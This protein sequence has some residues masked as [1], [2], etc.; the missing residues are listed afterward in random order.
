[1][2][3][4]NCKITG[5]SVSSDAYHQQK[6]ER[7][8]PR[9]PVSP[10]MLKSFA[11]CPSRWMA[12]YESAESDAKDFGSLLDTLVLTPEAFQDRYA[13]QPAEYTNEKGD[14]KTWH[15]GAGFCKEWNEHQAAGGRKITNTKDLLEAQIASKRIM[16]D[17]IL[18]GF[19]ND[20]DKQVLVEGE[21]H[22]EKTG[23]IIPVRCLIDLVPRL[24]T[25]FR[26]CLGD[27]KSTRSAALMAFQRDVF[28]LGYHLQ[29]AFDLDLYGAATGEERLTWCF[30]VQENYPPYEIG[31]RMLS[32]GEQ[33][34]GS[35]VEL[36]R[37]QYR[38]MLAQYARC[39][40]TGKWPSYDD[41]DESSDGW[42]VCAAEPW[43]ENQ[44]LF[45]PKFE[46]DDV[47]TEP[48]EAPVD[49]IP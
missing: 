42:S 9:L 23:L 28:R 30:A 2:S 38:R 8:D 43:M 49:I 40:K 48:P 32:G 11:H 13:V 41:S 20:S 17:E 3:F 16:A 14:K 7:G 46:T 44:V 35:Y 47:E 27:L 19:I 39:L 36:G 21:W 5:K 25:E 31:R 24:D 18:A 45:E 10:S 15:N 29:A 34:Q 22:D 6:F 37:V 4:Q 1:M 33:V 12:G 26:K